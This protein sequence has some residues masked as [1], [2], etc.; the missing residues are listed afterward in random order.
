LDSGLWTFILWAGAAVLAFAS[1]AWA[2]VPGLTGPLQ[3]LAQVLPQI[4][5][6]FAAGLAGLL[7]NRL[8]RERLG[9]AGR[10][11][12]T[13]KGMLAACAVLGV[14]TG[15]AFML[16]DAD[17]S[18]LAAAVPAAVPANASAKSAA[19]TMFRANLERTGSAGAAGAPVA[20]A[21]AWSFRD[22]QARVADLS[23]SP[24]VV[25][26][27]VYVGSAQ[28]SVFDSSGMVYCLDAATGKRIWQFQTEKQVFSSPAVVGGKVYVGE[29]LHV[30]TG[31]KLYCLD[32]ATGKKLWAAPTK[33][34]TESSPAVVG[35]RIYAGAG[36]DGVYCLDAATGKPIW[37]RGGMHIDASPA[38]A[39]G[40]LYLGTGYGQLRALALDAATGKTA[41]ETASDLPV[42]GPPAVA[43]GKVYFGTGNGDFVKSADAPKGAVLCLDAAT[44][45]Q[46]WR[47][48]LPDAALTAVSLAGTHAVTGCRDGKVYALDAASGT[49]AWSASCGGPV[50]ASPATDGRQLYVAG[51]GKITALDLNDGAAGWTLDLAAQTAA[52]VK[53]F[54]SPAVAG[55][56]LYV[57]TSKEKLFCI[58]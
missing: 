41:W 10:A 20:G 25:G 16:R 28:A 22:P 19:W 45:K 46:V 47:R 52:D 53:L 17:R 8:W 27:R 7:S 54:S 33:S 36:E 32:A 3:A 1:P 42:W 21:I 40:R 11:L 6:F 55:G 23:S 44:G 57:G 58:K 56:R 5:P 4:L 12:G 9:R 18:Q 50:V 24:A 51:G 34:H 35:N 26:G 2:V 30:D 49:I 31:C 39:N 14:G 37:H 48:D 13:P 38:V 43:G 29:G 15:A